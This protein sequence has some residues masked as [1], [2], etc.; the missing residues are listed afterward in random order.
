MP[1]AAPRLTAKMELIQDRLGRPLDQYLRESYWQRRRTFVEISRDLKR[2]TSV[3]VG[4]RTMSDWFRIF[5]IPT[6]H[7]KPEEREEAAV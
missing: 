6:S 4:L 3:H 7:R 1:T 5:D 2:L